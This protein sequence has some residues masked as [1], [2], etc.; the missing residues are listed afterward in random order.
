LDGNKRSGF[1]VK[2]ALLME[3]GYKLIASQ[4]EA[5]NAMIDVSTGTIGFEGLKVWLEGHCEKN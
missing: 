3:Y 2:V 1:T 5:Y 4:E